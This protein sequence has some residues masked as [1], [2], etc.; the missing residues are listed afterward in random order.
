LVDSFCYS[1]KNAELKGLTSSC[2]L[3]KADCLVGVSRH[4]ET[5][6]KLVV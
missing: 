2:S 1:Q 5:A 4:T 3:N 6:R